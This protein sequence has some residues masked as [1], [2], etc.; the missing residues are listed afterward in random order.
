[1]IFNRIFIFLSSMTAHPTGRLILSAH[2]SRDM[3]TPSFLKNEKANRVWVQHTYS[4]SSGEQA[5]DTTTFL[6]WTLIF[7]T[8]LLT[9]QG[10]TR[11]AGMEAQMSLLARG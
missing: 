6:R 4:V 9:F 3:T 10:C 11:H 1:M 5:G 8:N 7:P 2:F